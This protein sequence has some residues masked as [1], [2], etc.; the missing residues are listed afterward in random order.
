MHIYCL[1]AHVDHSGF[2]I[3]IPFLV[4]SW[5]TVP[6]LCVL[7]GKLFCM[8]FGYYKMKKKINKNHAQTKRRTRDKHCPEVGL[9]LVIGKFVMSIV[10]WWYCR[11]SKL[12]PTLS[13]SKHKFINSN[14]GIKSN[15][16]VIYL[17]NTFFFM[18][19]N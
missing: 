17:L 8:Q 2:F 6:T 19:L 9:F 15:Y 3:I 14:R 13:T 7:F 12:F 11:L 16:Y 18:H 4:S 1:R 10:T 5:N